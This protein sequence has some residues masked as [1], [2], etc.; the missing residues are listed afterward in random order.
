M[1]RLL[2]CQKCWHR[3]VLGPEDVQRGWSVRQKYVTILVKG[4]RC[5]RC[6]ASLDGDLTVA[7]TL[8]RV[9]EEGE[10]PDWEQTFG[11]ILSE[12]VI[13]V[14]LALTGD[15]GKLLHPPTRGLKD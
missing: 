15:K 11:P 8:F 13:S 5:D 7:T 3:V 2:W 6:N 14:Q 1:T 9:R 4:R 12:D 10:P